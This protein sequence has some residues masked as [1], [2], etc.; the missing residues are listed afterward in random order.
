MRT[1]N[2]P[3]NENEKISEGF[4]YRYR[5]YCCSFFLLCWHIYTVM[6][7]KV[8]AS[9]VAMARFDFKD[10]ITSKDSA[11]IMHWFAAQ[12]GVEHVLCNPE[13][14]II[15]F[16]FH[17]ASI[18][19][20]ALADKMHNELSYTVSRNIPSDKELQTGCPV[21]KDSKIYTFASKIFN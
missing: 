12:Q 11:T 20:T 6:K 10:N 14:K 4:T 3:K 21:K 8:D 1:C 18:N 13:T 2:K 19:A 17:P 9:T 5:Y 7:P 15:V 16:T